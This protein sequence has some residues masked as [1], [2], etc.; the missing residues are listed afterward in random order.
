MLGK[1][2][3]VV[4]AASMA[5]AGVAYASG[6]GDT[7]ALKQGKPAG[8]EKAI[9]ISDHETGVVLVGAAGAIAALAL[10]ASGDGHGSVDSTCTLLGCTSTTT[11]TNTTTTTTTKGSTTTTTNTH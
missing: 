5:F 3:G 1:F 11:T 4:I 7:A 2:A 8:V 9:S 10:V 6:S